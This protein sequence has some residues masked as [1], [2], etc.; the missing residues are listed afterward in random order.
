[1]ERVVEGV[2]GGG[3]GL[4]FSM[5]LAL[6]VLWRRGGREVG[7]GKYLLK[8]VECECGAP[9]PGTPYTVALDP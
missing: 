2:E 1:V 6:I 5:A 8:I 3:D 9:Q 7:R 4:L